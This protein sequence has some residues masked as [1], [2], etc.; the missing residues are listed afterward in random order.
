M[1][2]KEAT[3]RATLQD[4]I[5]AIVYGNDLSLDER[6]H[7]LGALARERNAKR[8]PKFGD[9][10]RN[11]WASE[12]NPQRDGYFVR[13]TRRT[14]RMNPG[15]WY[16]MTGRN[17]KFWEVDGSVQF[18]I[19]EPAKPAPTPAELGTIR[20]ALE[21]IDVEAGNGLS[22][23]RPGAWRESLS[24]IRKLVW[25]AN[26]AL[27]ARGAAQ[28]S[29][30][31]EWISVADRLPSRGESVLVL[32][33]GDVGIGG[34]CAPLAG[35]VAGWWF[36]GVNCDDDDAITHWMP[37]PAAPNLSI[38]APKIDASGERV[39]AVKVDEQGA[40]KEWLGEFLPELTINPVGENYGLPSLN[41]AW[42]AWKWRSSRAA[43][44]VA[45]VTPAG[46]KL[47]PVEPTDDMCD[48]PENTVGTGCYSCTPSRPTWGEAKEVYRAML[49]AAP[50]YEG[51]S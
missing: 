9:M 32:C 44:Q 51:E 41:I 5:D 16:Q 39:D 40:F 35:T 36:T 49:A 7:A 34:Y 18:F 4:D 12:S 47:V 43:L 26:M 28:D 29:V 24:E 11:P 46:W 31:A 37:P 48:A 14:G 20:A 17:G 6:R 23:V 38:P 50:T 25:D 22:T 45:P 3:A 33:G 1:N 13:S 27:D 19:D 2:A 10:M 42:A 8:T 15:L 21:S 30:P